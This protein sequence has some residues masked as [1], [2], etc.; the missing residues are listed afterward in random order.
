MSK[1]HRPNYQGIG[2]P[3]RR[4]EDR[5]FLTRA[6]PLRRRHRA[7]RRPCTACWCARRT[8]MPRIREV[9]GAAA[10][11]SPGVV[12][13]FTG[14]D[15]AA[16]RMAPI[17]RSGL[18][19][20]ATA[21]R[22]P[23]RR[24]SRSRATPSAMSASR[25]PRSS[26]K[27]C[28][29]AAD[30]AERVVID[31]EPL[32]AVTDARPG[33]GAGRA[34]AACLRPRQRLLPLGTWPIRPPCA[35]R[36][37]RPPTPWPQ[38]ISST[39]A[40]SAPRSS[41]ARSSPRL[42]PRHRQA[43]ALYL[44]PGSPSHPPPGDRAARHAGERVR[45]ALAR[46]RRRLRLQGQNLSRG[47][48]R[49]LGCAHAAPAGALGGDPRREL[50]RRQPGPATTSATAELALD[51]DGHFLALH[52]ADL[53][54]ARRLP[55]D[56]RSGTFRARSIPACSPAAT[57]RR[58]S[59]WRSP[60]CSPTPR[61]PTPFAAP[62][63]PE[64]CYVLE[65]LADRAAAQARPRPR[66]D[67]PA[68]PHPADRDAVQDADRSDLRLRRLPENLRTRAR[69]SPTMTASPSG[70]RRGGAARPAARHRHGLLC[71][72]L[73]CRAF[74][75]CRRAR[76][77]RRL[78]RGR[79]HP[80]RAGRRG[81]RHA[82]HPQSRPGPRH[83][84][85]ADHCRRGSACRSSTIEVVEGDTD[86]VPHGT[87]TFGSRSIAVGGSALDRAA[88]KIVAKGKLIAAHLL[89]AA[90]RR[91]RFRPTAAFTVAGTDRRIAVRRRCAGRLR[92]RT[93]FRPRPW[94]PGC[95]TTAVYD[96]PSFAFSNGAHVC[97]LEIDPDTGQH[98]ARRLLGAS[99]TSAPSSTR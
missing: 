47:R 10:I 94:S 6:R 19:A 17:G 96:P 37:A 34:A 9:D 66:R 80:H 62:G 82:R 29:Q 76:R 24:A 39:T 40:W 77:P 57:A 48:H 90:R 5:R 74:A 51:V 86:A 73:G 68:Q 58:R 18:S 88:D 36:C 13:V 50:P 49:H 31:Y 33:A 22:W 78:L 25:S 23:S 64:A 98:R 89:E 84:L 15:M 4:V 70:A 97:E 52:V 55:L 42:E 71:R 14:A 35:R 59:S 45:V 27:A 3:L 81:A 67:P 16:D 61:R 85:R 44:H 21:R 28:L 83:H 60:A 41:R 8:P 99:T 12:A 65:R 56:L 20:R 7:A 75:L 54:G 93:T 87:G 38:S 46:C 63:R 26:P 79:I 72:I 92:C 95:R 69:R 32:P 53:C 11:A 30:A 43:H 1:Q 91:H 2:A